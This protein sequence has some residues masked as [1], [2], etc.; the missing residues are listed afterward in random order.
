MI[1]A[2]FRELLS[3][4]EFGVQADD[5]VDAIFVEKVKI[6]LWGMIRIPIMNLNNGSCT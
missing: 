1:E 4:V 6:N 2:G 5:C 3:V